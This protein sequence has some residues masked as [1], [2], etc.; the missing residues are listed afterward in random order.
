MMIQRTMNSAR[1]RQNKWPR[2]VIVFLSLFILAESGTSEAGKVVP[3]YILFLTADGFRTDYI[4]W[5]GPTN[6]QRL[7]AE[8]V[9]VTHAKNVFPTV[10]TPNMTSLVT[11]AYPRTTGIACNTQYVKEEDRIVKN[12][13]GNKA[14]TIAETLQKAGWKTA[15]VNHFMLAGRGT[16][17][18]VAPGYDDSEKT[19]DAVLAAL[20]KGARFVGAIYGATDHAGHGHGPRSE[21][22]KQ[23]VMQIDHA[24][25]RL[26]AG[27][28][29]QGILD[30][31]LIT[32]NS[33]HGM[34]AFEKQQVSPEP[35]QALRAAGFQVASSEAELKDETDIVMID[36]GVRLVYFR[37]HMSDE[38]KQDAVKVLAG[39]RGAEIL[40]RTR[41]D[42]LGCHYNR[43]GDL[44]LSPLPGYTMSR[45]GSTGGLHGRFP[46]RNPILLFYGPGFKRGATVEAAQT[47]DVV[48]TLLRAVHVP[49]AVTV[50]GKV[51]ADALEK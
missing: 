6:L 42:A 16:D 15:G 21:E 32:F 41:L 37:E 26:L 31:T 17:S 51:I 7:I 33:D 9:R 29:E 36:A 19:T 27:L 24:I 50:D 12:P 48:P 4:E 2:I 8:G 39:I 1:A 44:I 30:Q 13:R 5:Y 43:S 49:P 35:I 14:E 40:D 38:A 10:T 28:K 3:K 11:G 22:V 20:K 23:A 34:S 46:E 25:G 47:I 18:Y 45:A